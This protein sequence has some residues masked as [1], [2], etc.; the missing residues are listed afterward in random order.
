M[1]AVQTPSSPSAASREEDGLAPRLSNAHQ[2]AIRKNRRLTAS[3]QRSCQLN[4]MQPSTTGM[5]S[6]ERVRRAGRPSLFHVNNSRLQFKFG[7]AEAKL[8]RE[9]I[10]K[11]VD[12]AYCSAIHLARW[13]SYIKAG[14]E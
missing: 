6:E 8:L 7:K 12:A 2:T 10:A 14:I 13:K 4:S 3:L 11:R 5:L 1:I 9:H